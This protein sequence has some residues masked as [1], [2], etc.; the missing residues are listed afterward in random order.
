MATF[1]SLRRVP[2]WYGFTYHGVALPKPMEGNSKT[3]EAADTV[4][5][6]TVTVDLVESTGSTV[7]FFFLFYFP[8]SALLSCFP[9]SPLSLLF[10]VCP[11]VVCLVYL[12]VVA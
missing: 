5:V 9:L 7:T 12:F 8:F 1:S 6:D 11:F 2:I 10:V 4:T 3:I